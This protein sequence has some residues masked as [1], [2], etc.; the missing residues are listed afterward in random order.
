MPRGTT[1]I[2]AS[3]A[4]GSLRVLLPGDVAVRVESDVNFGSADVLGRESSGVG[5]D[6]LIQDA[7]YRDAGRRLELQIDTTFGSAEVER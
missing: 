7:G 3:I 4:F 2:E 5:T 6:D 1:R